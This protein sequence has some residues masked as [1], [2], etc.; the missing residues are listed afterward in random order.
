MSA[1]VAE[2]AKSI[3]LAGQR[4]LPGGPVLDGGQIRE[5]AE[6]FAAAR[7]RLSD[8]DPAPQPSDEDWARGLVDAYWRARGRSK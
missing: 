4:E 8:V 5:A 3:A 1:F 6:D 7:Q 2:L